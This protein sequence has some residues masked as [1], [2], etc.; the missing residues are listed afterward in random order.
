MVNLSWFVEKNLFLF[1][2]GPY[3]LADCA[4]VSRCMIG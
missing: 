1:E 2:F 4:A 3:D